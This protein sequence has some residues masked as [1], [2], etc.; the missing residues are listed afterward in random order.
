MYCLPR[1]VASVCLTCIFALGFATTTQAQFTID[2]GAGDFTQT[3]EFNR[4]ST[5]DFSIGINEPLA[6]GG[7]YTNPNLSIVDYDVFGILTEPTPSNF[8]AFNLQRTIVGDEF[9][10]HLLIRNVHSRAER[11][12]TIFAKQT[13]CLTNVIKPRAGRHEISLGF[14]QY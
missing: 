13:T 3:P 14:A 11:S 9:Y 8:S 2:F 5:F 7:V 12:A 10:T 1:V 4:L 6:A